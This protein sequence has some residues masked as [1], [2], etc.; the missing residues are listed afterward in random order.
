MNLADSI[1][2]LNA[3][4][5]LAKQ[6]TFKELQSDDV[7][8][9]EIRTSEQGEEQDKTIQQGLILPQLSDD[10]EDEDLKDLSRQT[11]DISVYKYFFKHVSLNSTV[12][13]FSVSVIQAF[14]CVFPQVILKW[15]SDRGGK[16]DVQYIV[17]YIL[18]AVA[19]MCFGAVAI[20][21]MLILIV[22]E[23]AV[24]LHHAL[25]KA[26][27]KAPQSF[28]TKTDRGITLNRFSQDMTLIDTTLAAALL[29]TTTQF[30]M[31]LAQ[32]SMI[33]LGSTWMALTIPL[34]IVGL[35]FLQYVYLR[36]SRQLRYLDLEAKSPVYTQFIET[37][38]G[39]ATIR[40]FGWGKTSTETNLERLDASQ[41]PHYLLYCVQ[42]WLNLVLDLMV[43]FL[44][45]VV[46]AMAVNLRAFTSA[47]LLGIALNN[48]SSSLIIV[49]PI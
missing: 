5:T 48:V 8:L 11:G 36:T 43:M 30:F 6:T 22:P 14:A 12:L 40:A 34:L 23:A 37:L 1:I 27:M 42:R 15:W 41:R 26:I 31:V 21:G 7:F 4:G 35:Y 44:A 19:S 9:R 25:L 20:W 13:Y 49:L 24:K 18:L 32:A 39:I 45:V 10:T 29:I 46:V 17:P 16:L 38:D 3:D 2:I 33:S 28:F 47:G